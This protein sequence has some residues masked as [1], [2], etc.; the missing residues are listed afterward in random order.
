RSGVQSLP[1]YL[2]RRFDARVRL[3]NSWLILAT[4]TAL[5][6]IGLYAVAEVL[7]VVFGWKFTDGAFLAAGIVMI[8][9]ILGGL[10]ATIYNEVFQLFIIVSGLSPLLFRVN[11]GALGLSQ[12]LAD[13]QRH[14]WLGLQPFSPA[15]SLDQFGVVIG[16]GFVLSFS[17]WCTD[18]VL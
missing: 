10:R 6:G 8:Y 2:E 4:C 9:V 1:E 5:S 16:L 15:S 17:Y 13:S 12:H 14:L 18:F 11:A 7:H 3:I